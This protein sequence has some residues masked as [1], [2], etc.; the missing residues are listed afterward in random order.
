LASA[1]HEVSTVDMRA[2]GR[3]AIVQEHDALMAEAKRRKEKALEAIHEAKENG[4]KQKI[5]K[6]HEKK[7]EL[8]K[9]AAVKEKA[10]LRLKRAAEKKIADQAY[11]KG[12]ADA[13]AVYQ[14]QVAA[15]RVKAV[16]KEAKDLLKAQGPKGTPAVPPAMPK[17]GSH[18]EAE[19]ARVAK[20]LVDQA[21]HDTA[22]GAK[23]ESEA[24]QDAID[25]LREHEKTAAQAVMEKAV[26]DTAA[27][28][29]G[30]TATSDAID[31]LRGQD[32]MHGQQHA[33]A[34]DEAAVDQAV[35]DT[36]SGKK[37]AHEAT[38]AAIDGLDTPGS[39]SKP[40]N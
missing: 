15:M 18:P 20:V 8:A 4:E 10:R 11:A 32:H 30:H 1:V 28:K 22:T 35:Q 6:A 19:Y 21:V 36:A 17:Q 29:N 40:M 12:R 3:A 14:R 34:A 25:G 39:G 38:A 26:H 24:V 13:D 23:D 5:R 27:G 7:A 33:K 31:Q 9:K 2:R 37:Q 16:E